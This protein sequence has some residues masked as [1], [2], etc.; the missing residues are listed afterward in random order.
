MLTL[1]E[2][3][4]FLRIEHSEEDLLLSSLIQTADDFIKTATHKAAD[5]T[6]GRFKLA[7]MLIAGHW[8]ENRGATGKAEQL[9]YHLESLLIQIT[10]ETEDTL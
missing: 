4:Q 8:Y 5:N 10:C 2:L 3:K 6:A 1:D 9:P 7:Q